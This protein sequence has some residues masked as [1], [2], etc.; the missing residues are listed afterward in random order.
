MLCFQNERLHVILSLTR[1]W[2][3]FFCL[4]NVRLFSISSLDSTS[5]FPCSLSVFICFSPWLSIDF[6]IVFFHKVFPK[7]E[8]LILVC[9][10]L[11]WSEGSISSFV[12]CPDDNDYIFVSSL[13]ISCCSFP[14]LIL[15]SIFMMNFY[16]LSKRFFS[17][18]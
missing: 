14:S 5:C 6:S 8:Y 1:F 7:G 17:K 18:T 10:T 3:I 9:S 16:I 11:F 15:S 4:L 12:R 13:L 2:N